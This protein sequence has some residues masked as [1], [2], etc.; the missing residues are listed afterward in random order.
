V[1]RDF[2]I[3]L[4]LSRENVFKLMTLVPNK[5]GKGCYV[6]SDGCTCA[7]LSGAEIE[8]TTVYEVEGEEV[9]EA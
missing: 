8:L 6:L 4:Y 9:K 7:E 3:R 2:K 1:S 5:A